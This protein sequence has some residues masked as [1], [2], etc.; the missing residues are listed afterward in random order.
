MS[1][2]SE[3]LNL[4]EDVLDYIIPGHKKKRRAQIDKEVDAERKRGSRS[5]VEVSNRSDWNR[6]A[7]DRQDSLMQKD[8]GK[9]HYS[10][11]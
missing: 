4:A 10:M 1:R 2:A 6:Y 5:S 9:S 11:R 7:A 3:F 8:R